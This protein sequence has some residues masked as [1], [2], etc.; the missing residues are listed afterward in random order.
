M[1]KGNCSVLMA[2]PSAQTPHGRGV[3]ETASIHL[4]MRSGNE[5]YINFV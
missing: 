2:E 5:T 1:G 3:F 4:V